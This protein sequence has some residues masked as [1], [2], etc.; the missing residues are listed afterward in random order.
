MHVDDES[1]ARI[2]KASVSFD[3]KTV[4]RVIVVHAILGLSTNDTT[5]VFQ[6]RQA[7]YIT[8][9]SNEHLFFGGVKRR[10]FNDTLKVFLKDFDIG[11]A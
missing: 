2:V 11:L 3:R 10:L 5:L 7:V 6:P 1:N 4:N 9:I 8:S